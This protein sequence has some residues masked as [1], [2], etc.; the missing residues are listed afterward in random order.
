MVEREFWLERWQNDELGFHRSD[1]NPLLETHWPGLGITRGSAVFVP[2]CG[3]SLDMRYLESLGHPV[4]GV[5]YSEKA[6]LA[7]FEEGGEESELTTGFYLKRY[8]GPRTTIYRGDF[9]DLSTSDILGIRAVFDRGALVA[10]P[11]SM[12]ERYVDH[13]LRIIPEHAHILLVTLE[14]DQEKVAGPPFSVTDVEI[15][16]LFAS[17]SRISPV[18]KVVTTELPPRF[19]RAGIESVMEAVYHIVKEH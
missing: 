18:E 1:T 10:L 13:M 11:E 19:A 15:N 14:Y 17:R 12:R 6:V 9:F 4:F 8:E 7:Y 2:L 5:E 16:R 3:K